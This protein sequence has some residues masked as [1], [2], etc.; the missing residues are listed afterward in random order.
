MEELRESEER[1]RTLIQ[2]SVEAI[3]MFNP[4][5]KLVLEANTTFLN[6]LGYTVEEIQTLTIYDFV[7]QERK[8][9]DTY[10]QNILTSTTIEEGIWLRKDGTP[11]DVQLTAS[12]IQQGGRDIIF[13][14]ARDITESKRVQEQI[15]E[16]ERLAAVGQLAAGIAHD[17]N[18]ILTGIVGY[19]QLLQM[20]ANVAEFIKDDLKQVEAGG[21]RAAN[22]IR[23]ILDFSRKSIIQRQSLDLV[24]F[25]KETIKFLER[26]IPE[27]IH[28][29]LE[30]TPGE[31]L[32]SA[33]PT[34]INQVLTNLAVNAKD[35]MPEGGEL[36]F[37]LSTFTLAP[38]ERPPLPEIPPGEWIVLSVLD[39]GSGIPPEIKEHI[40]EPFAT[41][42]NPGEGTG[43]GLAQVH[44]IVKQ[45]DGFIDVESS[46][47]EGTTFIIYLPALYVEKETPEEE[48]GSEELLLGQGETILVVED[49]SSVLATIRDMLEQAGYRVLTATNGQEGVGMYDRHKNEIALVLADMVMPV[50]GGVELFHVLK[51]QNPDVKV[52]VISG[53]PLGEEAE[54]FLSQGIVGWMQKPVDFSKLVRMVHETL[55]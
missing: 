18:N 40:F 8:S 16:R 53:Y 4:E 46:A 24:S 19:A 35:A 26:T 23:Q 37:R 5:T 13:V 36:K 11:I 20:D 51:A 47:E 25:L 39:T 1:Y 27:S 48:E 10:I 33:D 9:V 17:F 43:L 22:L 52:V 38:D 32:V 41:T 6:L 7:A 54:E 14:V 21:H 30:M 34:Q 45:H 42:K 44:G 49:E 50:M 29:T 31:Y 3:Y 28:I 15:Q 12:R 55:T 2:Q